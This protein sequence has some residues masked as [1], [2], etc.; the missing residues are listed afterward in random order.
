[1]NNRSVSFSIALKQAR[2][3]SLLSVFPRCSACHVRGYTVL[4]ERRFS[5]SV[6]YTGDRVRARENLALF[7]FRIEESLSR[8]PWS[9]KLE[10]SRQLFPFPSQGDLARWASECEL[11]MRA[12]AWRFVRLERRHRRFRQSELASLPAIPTTYSRLRFEIWQPR[13]LVGPIV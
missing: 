13:Q 11:K 5:I 12:S 8:H 6:Y 7:L 9:G 4:N 10:S 1:M 3:S 2:C